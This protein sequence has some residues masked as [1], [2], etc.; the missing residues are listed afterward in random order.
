MATKKYKPSNNSD[1]LN[2]AFLLNTTATELLCAI[3]NGQ[4]DP[5]ELVKI[6]LANRGLDNNGQWIGFNQSKKHFKIK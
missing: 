2:P 6:E 4:I 5:I 3:V 1:E